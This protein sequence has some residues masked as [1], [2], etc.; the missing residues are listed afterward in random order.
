MSHMT[1]AVNVQI[2]VIMFNTLFLF[3]TSLPLT[4][5]KN[6]IGI[7]HPG[8]YGSVVLVRHM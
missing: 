5:K 4:L 7:C 1:L 3:I 8:S 2:Q 6:M